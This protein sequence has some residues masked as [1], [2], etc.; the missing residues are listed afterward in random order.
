[1]PATGNDLLQLASRHIN[2]KY[3]LGIEVPKDNANWTG[4]WDCAQ[5]ASR[6]GFQVSG[7]LYGCFNDLGNP[8]TADAYT[9]YWDRDAAVLG[10]IV[11]IEE[12]GRTPGAAVLRRP[13]AGSIGHIVFSDG[14]GGTVEAHSHADGVIKSHLAGRRWDMGILIP[15][16]T[17][18]P[19]ASITV[20]PP[21][22]TIFRLTLPPMSGPVVQQIQTNLKQK[23]FDPGTIDG[24]FGPHTQA[25]VTA[26][27]LTLGLTPDGEVGPTT[28]KALGI[29]L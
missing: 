7:V 25:A 19:G 4:P 17:Y 13:Q 6:V 21:A 20:P 18:Q 9:G 8:A 1:M 10:H 22:T 24:V 3:Q 14:T 12:A 27:Q 28:A 29:S 23:G 5:F 16:I 15:E 2:E 11:T 26:L